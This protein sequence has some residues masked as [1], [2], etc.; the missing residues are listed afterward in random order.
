MYREGVKR[1]NDNEL[2]IAKAYSSMMLMNGMSIDTVREI[3]DKLWPNEVATDSP[4]YHD[5]LGHIKDTDRYICQQ[6][7]DLLGL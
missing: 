4:N 3:T 6:R 1:M 7:M 2:S 5:L